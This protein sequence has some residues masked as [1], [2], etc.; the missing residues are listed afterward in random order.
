VFVTDLAVELLNARPALTERLQSC[1]K[2]RL[3][4][5]SIEILKENNFNLSRSMGSIYFESQRLDA[6]PVIQELYLLLFDDD[7]LSKQLKS[8]TLWTIAQKRHLT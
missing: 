7:E 1:R 8:K 4:D 6:L 5:I 3:P 2:F